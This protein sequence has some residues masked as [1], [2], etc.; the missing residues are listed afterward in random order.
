MKMK[1]RMILVLNLLALIIPVLVN[2]RT[3]NQYPWGTDIQNPPDDC[4]IRISTL[5]S[6]DVDS[7]GGLSK[8]EF[9]S[10]LSSRNSELR[11]FSSTLSTTGSLGWEALVAYYA[12]A[13]Y[14][15]MLG[16]GGG[17]CGGS[18][19]II[20]DDNI[21]SETNSNYKEMM[22]QQIDHV[23]KLKNNV[24]TISPSTSP[25][26]STHVAESPGVELTTSS[27]SGAVVSTYPLAP[28]VT[29]HVT[30]T[31]PSSPVVTEEYDV[32]VATPSVI[33]TMTIPTDTESSTTIMAVNNTVTSSPSVMADEVHSAPFASSSATMT[34]KT[35][36]TPSER[37]ATTPSASG[38][39]AGTS[40][41]STASVSS[42][43]GAD[44][45]S[46]TPGVV[47]KD[48]GALAIAFGV[49]SAV[50]V[51]VL[52]GLIVAR[53]RK[54]RKKLLAMEEAAAQEDCEIRWTAE[55]QEYREVEDDANGSRGGSKRL[56]RRTLV[57]QQ[58][59]RACW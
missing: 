54:R 1:C 10:F 47:A 7:S 9:F 40:H 34:T 36:T 56:A 39:V 50:L 46:A 49:I 13:C 6:F 26:A 51:A 11:S 24:N 4:D 8:D 20:I 59:R 19:E 3:Q 44:N 48:H 22:C 12:M 35:T 30:T 15:Q 37:P 31:K 42:A 43:V 5:A 55:E 28:V 21:L 2:A 23:L 58:K 14:C 41:T 32:P 45:D 52:V 53:R 38:F 27:S 29:N 18:A 57:L 33:T 16:R 17:C 25:A